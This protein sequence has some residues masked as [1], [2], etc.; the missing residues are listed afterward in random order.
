MAPKIV[1][2]L[3]QDAFMDL[4]DRAKPALEKCNYD[5]T[6]RTVRVDVHVAFQKITLAVPAVNEDHGELD[7]ARC[8]ANA[9]KD[10]QWAGFKPG[11]SGI[12]SSVKI[13][14]P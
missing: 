5:K 1:G 14:W 8:C 11:E 9:L 13:T 12:Y 4:V 10:A 7:V 3:R 6:K 2:Q